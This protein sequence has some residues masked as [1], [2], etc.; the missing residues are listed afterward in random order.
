[1]NRLVESNILRAHDAY[2]GFNTFSPWMLITL[3]EPTTDN[4][5]SHFSK[6]GPST[7]FDIRS[8]TVETETFAKSEKRYAK[9]LSVITMIWRM[10]NQCRKSYK[11]N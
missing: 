5:H 9:R 2:L 10:N 8:K 1:M 11:E 3:T 4:F 7:T 6:R